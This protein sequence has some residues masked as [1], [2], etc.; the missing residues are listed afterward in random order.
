MESAVVIT[1]ENPIGLSCK[2]G[3]PGRRLLYDDVTLHA[4]I[5]KPFHPPFVGTRPHR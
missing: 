4:T 3:A 2:N 1:D 5:F